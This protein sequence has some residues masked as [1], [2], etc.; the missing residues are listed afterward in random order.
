MTVQNKDFKNQ[1]NSKMLSSQAIQD[2]LEKY[3]KDDN[4]DDTTEDKNYFFL[5]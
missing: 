3:K 4:D 2:I 5:R 1:E